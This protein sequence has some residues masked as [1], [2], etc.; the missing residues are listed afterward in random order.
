MS[1]STWDMVHFSI[2]LLNLKPLT[3]QTWSTD[4]CKEGQY[5]SEIFWAIQKTGAKLQSLFN[6]ATCSNYSRTNYVKFP[7]LHFLKGRIENCK[8]QLHKIDRSRYI[9]ISLKSLKGLELVSSSQQWA[10]NMLEMF[11]IRYTSMWPNFILIVLRIQK[12]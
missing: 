3:H 6:L 11:V 5:F 8:Y 9:V 1:I 10:R 4:K 2:Y 7:V 12:K